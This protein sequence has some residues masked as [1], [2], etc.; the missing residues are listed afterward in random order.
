MRLDPKSIS[1]RRLIHKTTFHTGHFPVSMHLLS[2][3]VTDSSQ[4]RAPSPTSEDGEESQTER[5]RKIYQ[6]LVTTQTGT[7]GLMTPVD[8]MLYLRLNTLQT[9]LNAQLENPCGLNPR[10]YRAVESERM[11]IKGVLDGST[12]KRWTELPKQRRVD[13][14]TRMGVDES[15]VR[16]DLETILGGSLAL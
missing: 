12:L 2:G 6:V 5:K 11:G 8:E 15:S 3:L 9:Y 1:G 14:C 7:I 10:G 4:S 16:R 13:A